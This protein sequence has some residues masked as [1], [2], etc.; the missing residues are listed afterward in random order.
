MD[1]Q[2]TCWMGAGPFV[3][4]D[5]VARIPLHSGGVIGADKRCLLGRIAASK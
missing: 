3:S 5:H 1:K 2:M 4:R